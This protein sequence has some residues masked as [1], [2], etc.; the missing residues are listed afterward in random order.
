[1][2]LRSQREY[3]LPQADATPAMSPRTISPRRQVLLAAAILAIAFLAYIPALHGGFL[4]DDYT[5]L[6]NN[7]LIHTS[8]GLRRFW[9]TAQAED[10]FPLTSSMLWIEWRIWGDHAAGYHA[11]NLL[12]H[13]V[14]AVLVWRVLRRLAV[15]GAWLAG[16]LFAV[17]PVAVASAAWITERKNT[18][19]MVLYLLS[20]L[21][22]LRFDSGR[23]H[24]DDTTG[25]TN[26][27]RYYLV[28]LGLFLLALLAKTSGVML[29]AVLLLCAWWQ[30]GKITRKDIL[31]SLPFFA[32]ALAL[33]LVTVWFQQHNV[34][35]HQDVHPEGWAS[36]VAAT[37][38]IIG[39]YLFKALVPARLCAVYPRWNVNPA[40]PVAFLPLALIALGFALL[41]AHRRSWGRAP[42]FAMSCFVL[43]L[44]PVLG[45]VNMSF[46]KFSL[47]ADHFQYAALVGVCAFVAAVL[48]RAS[49]AVGWRGRMGAFAIVV[50]V[51]ALAVLTW[52]RARLYADEQLLWRDEV[53]KEP[54]PWLAWNN[55]GDVCFRAGRPDQALEC[56]RRSSL[57]N[58]KYAVAWLNLGRT[59]AV[60]GDAGEALNDYNKAIELMPDFASAYNGRGNVQFHAGKYDLALEDY[61][62]AIQFDPFFADAYND[63]G[64][65]RV[66]QGQIADAIRDFDEAIA[67]NPDYAPA[68]S[69]R[70]GAYV[71]IQEFQQAL[72]DSNRAIALD[73]ANADYFNNRGV[74]YENLKR[75]ELALSDF[76]R[77]ISLR[78]GL[79]NAYIS[80]AIVHYEL[81]DFEK[82]WKDVAAAQKL[83]GVVQP[84]FLTQLTHDSGRAE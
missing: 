4:W 66:K 23:S 82:A 63:R 62:K 49:A 32:L 21:A 48:A 25:A 75:H 76:D 71:R 17:H 26:G 27:N 41:W 83:G 12:L 78:P 53:V 59:N 2:P 79:V 16:V 31:R 50:C 61:E 43:I 30:R 14:A 64:N 70:A 37:G 69:D 33:G 72:S 3:M 60:T 22:W 77:A 6:K 84:E 36:R 57:L 40:S 68:F 15:P 7:W 39:F 35:R 81:K 55:L 19:P 45:L 42:L 24:H 10:Y 8:D 34:I 11:I 29:P 73:P 67:L 74:V 1:M 56:F 18:L 54:I 20:L 52:S 38:W 5:F 13:A 44:L 28:S 46:M 9:F 58:P 47:V 51:A 65:V 80:R